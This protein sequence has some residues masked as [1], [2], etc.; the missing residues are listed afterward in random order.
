MESLQRF[1]GSL[2]HLY[3]HSERCPIDP[4]E[5]KPQRPPN[6]PIAVDLG[7]E[8]AAS[9]HAAENEA[10][11]WS[12][13][14]GETMARIVDWSFSLKIENDYPLTELI[15]KAFAYVPDYAQSLNQCVNFIAESPLWLYVEIK[16]E[17]VARDPK[18]Q[19][20]IWTLADLGKKRLHGWD[21]SLPIPGIVIDGVF[22]QLYVFFERS[23]NLVSRWYL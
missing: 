20:A 6:Y 5:V 13:E 11:T 8:F 1:L 23:G 17:H 9:S 16:K 18:V 12:E 7:H 10:K 4:E 21:T 14:G 2:T 3:S 15:N 19:L 22:W